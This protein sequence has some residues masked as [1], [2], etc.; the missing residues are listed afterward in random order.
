MAVVLAICIA[1]SIWALMI[2]NRLVRLRIQVRTAWA[3]IDVQLLRRHDLVPQLVAAV[4][5]YAAHE[6]SVMQ[7]VTELRTRA[8]A[9]RSPARLGEVEAALEQAIG[10][11]FVLKEAYPELKASD[12]FAQLQRDLVAVEE[13][14]Q[15]ARRFYNGAVRDLNDAVQRVPDTL[16][17]RAF[18]FESAEFFQAQDAARPAVRV[19]IA[20]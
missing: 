6:K 13:Q 14:L 16:I 12:N 4:K 3:D 5:A 9:L 20:P 11:V 8:V 2:Y 17:A 19:E 7:A 10:Q 1:G 15:Y 18:A